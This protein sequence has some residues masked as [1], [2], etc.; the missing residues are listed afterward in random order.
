MARSPVPA[1]HHTATVDRD[2]DGPATERRLAN[3]VPERVLRRV[4][5]WVDPNNPESESAA[6]FPHHEVTSPARVGPANTHA[7][8]S[9]ISILN[10][11][12]G[13]ADVSEKDRRAIYRHLATHLK[14]A[15]EDP[16]PL[17]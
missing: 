10:G 15:G 3:D 13:G 17:K 1:P 7:L 5:A 9:G 8:R 6:K 4:F 16:P 14:D 2:W 11:G 12:R